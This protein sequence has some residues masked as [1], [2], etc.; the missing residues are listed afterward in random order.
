MIADMLT[1][2]QLRSSE[3]LD[4]IS[5]FISGLYISQCARD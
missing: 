4:Y 1:V 3:V 5:F 2:C